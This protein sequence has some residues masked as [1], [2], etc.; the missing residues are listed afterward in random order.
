MVEISVDQPGRLTE[1]GNPVEGAQAPLER[2][3]LNVRVFGWSDLGRNRPENQDQFLIAELANALFITHASLASADTVQAER[4][5]H[6]F[7]VAD[8]VGGAPG[9]AKASALAITQLGHA[10]LGN[11]QTVFRLRPSSRRGV[12]AALRLAFRQADARIWAEVERRPALVGMATTLTAAFSF[13]RD[14]YL[15]HAGDSRG[16]LLRAG[17]LH[18]LTRDHVLDEEE[19]PGEGPRPRT[20][21]IALGA[22]EPGVHPDLRHLQLEAE[23][24]LLLC[25]D[26]LTDMLDEETIALTL[27]DEA[28]PERA[29]HRLVEQAND[30]GG[31]DNLTAVVA[32]YDL[33][34]P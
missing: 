1:E 6:L 25:T 8:G 20:V 3:P 7:A 2:G 9:G 27:A 22:P 26:G 14:L 4:K 28:D 19:S 34:A 12:L 31:H 15:A 23:D 13:H 16:Y 30:R 32:R 5:G 21:T 10:V 33:P 24:V 17:L 11:L 29:C 18:R